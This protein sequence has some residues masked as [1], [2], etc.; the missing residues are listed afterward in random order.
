MDQTFVDEPSWMPLVRILVLV[1][2]SDVLEHWMPSTVALLLAGLLALAMTFL[3]AHKVEPG[4]RGRILRSLPFLLYLVVGINGVI[5]LN[6]RA[7]L[8]IWAHGLMFAGYLL[9][10]RW[11]F[12]VTFQKRMKMH[13]ALWLLMSV[14]V[15]FLLTLIS[16][17]G[18][19]TL[20]N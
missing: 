4:F 15:G 5:Y 6:C 18:P 1:V 13:F 11:L 17:E 10:Y 2:G 7:A 16:V 9:L 19:C 3:F 20:I 12:T 14:S 8:P